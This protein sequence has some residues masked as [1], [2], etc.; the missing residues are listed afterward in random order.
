VPRYAQVQVENHSNPPGDGAAWLGQAYA[1]FHC[2][3]IGNNTMLRNMTLKVPA[4]Q[5]ADRRRLLAAFDRLD[6]AVDQSGAVADLDTFQQQAVTVLHG[7]TR[8]ALDLT[9]ESPEV[10]ERYGPGV[11]EEL[12]LARRLCEAGCGFVTINNGFWDHHTGL[13]NGCRQ[14]CPP[15]DRAVSAFLDD[16]RQRGL[17]DDILLV[18]TGE[19]G[20]TPY[21][22]GNGRDHWPGLNPLVLAGGGLKTGQV[23]GESDRRGGYPKARAVRPQDLMATLFQVLGID[24]ALQF[25]DPTGR[26]VTMIE[27]GNPIAELF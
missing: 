9:R 27:E 13:V 2:G 21:H 8:E 10:R 15:L 11:G 1:P 24:P 4:D 18:M 5:L 25:Q 7:R 20:R 26:P 14:L 22:T 23:V 19:F 17:E 3:R 16:V 6:R 12:L